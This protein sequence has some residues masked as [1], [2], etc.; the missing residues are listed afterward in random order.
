[1]PPMDLDFGTRELAAE[2]CSFLW[3]TIYT[4]GALSKIQELEYRFR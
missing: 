2:N 3:Q 4:A 1:M